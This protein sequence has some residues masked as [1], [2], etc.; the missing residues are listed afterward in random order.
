MSID[1]IFID[2]NIL[3]YAHD[4]DAGGKRDRARELV[5]ELWSSGKAP[6]ISV[7]VL[8]ELFVNLHRRGVSVEEAREVVRDYSTWRVA[9]NTVE[10]CVSATNEME[11]WK[12][13]FWDGLILAAAR[14]MRSSVLWSE[15]F[16]VGQSYSGIT[17]LNPLIK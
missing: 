17:V 2:T 15:D 10:L 16:N 12:V 6:A 11:Q 3:V 5:K 4:R 9:E 13:S 14:A 7:Q 8:Q 1:E